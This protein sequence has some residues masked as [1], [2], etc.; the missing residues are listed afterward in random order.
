M[1]PTFPQS[2]PAGQQRADFPLLTTMHVS[3]DGQQKFPGKFP[4]LHFV[5]FE[6]KQPTLSRRTSPRTR[7]VSIA[8]ERAVVVG[9]VE[10]IR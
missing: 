1:V 5:K 2:L 6:L 4:P 9:I 3:A 8:A 10:Y 7:A